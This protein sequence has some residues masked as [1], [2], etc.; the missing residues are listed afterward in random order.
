MLQLNPTHDFNTSFLLF[1]TLINSKNKD[2]DF[3]MKFSPNFYNGST[4]TSSASQHRHALIH[5][6]LL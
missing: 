5:F 4:F 3:T 6:L 1:P 2:H